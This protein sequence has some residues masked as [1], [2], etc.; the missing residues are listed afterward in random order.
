MER[1]PLALIMVAG[2][3]T[4]SKASF[5]EFMEIWDEKQKY[6]AKLAKRSR[7]I[8]EGSLDD[9]IDLPWDIGISEL[10][11]NARN[12]LEILSFLDPENIPQALLVGDHNE[13]YLEFLNSTEASL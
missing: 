12:L 7:L 8:A 9:S 1:L 11:V 10:S 2:Y 6:R 5:N 3:V 4:V 13:K